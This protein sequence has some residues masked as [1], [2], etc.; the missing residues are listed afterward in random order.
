MN[1]LLEGTCRAGGVPSNFESLSHTIGDAAISSGNPERLKAWWLYRCLYS[2]RPLEERLTLMWHNHFATSNSKVLDLTLMKQQN[3][4][5]RRYGLSPF[6]ELLGAMS[7]DPALLEWLD[8]PTNHAGRPN[9]NF[10]R[11]MMELFTLGVGNYTERDVSETAR[12][13]TG[14]TVRDSVFRVNDDHHDRE[15]KT[16]LGHTGNWSGDDVIGFLLQRPDCARRIAWRLTNE[17]CGEH[18]VS[19]AA[20]MELADGLREHNLDI[21][22]GV[23]TILRSELFFSDANIQSRVTDPV[24]YLLIPLRALE[25]WNSPPAT[26]LLAE[27]LDKLGQKLF[28][29]P[30]VA[31]WKGGR[32]WLSTRTII[33]RANYATAL[34]NGKLSNPACPLK[35][36]ASLMAVAGEDEQFRRLG[37]MLAGEVSAD[38]IS[39]SLQKSSVARDSNERLRMFVQD[40]M[41]QPNSQL[42]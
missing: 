7:H 1:R 33:A 18:V 14:W 10:A 35:T 4:T 42:H 32:D 26:Y 17:F 40:V 2:P 29:P 8:A 23:Q 30:N 11:E 38:V 15:E 27:W 3:E 39:R 36:P 19:Q 22:W 13:F 16:I 34:A 31:G 41:I 20:L 5:L 28:L 9:E 21:R 6:G 24:S 12:A 25:C 37:Q